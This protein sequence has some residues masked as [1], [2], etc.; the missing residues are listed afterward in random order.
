MGGW[1]QVW[2]HQI[3]LTS[4]KGWNCSWE[5][6]IQPVHRLEVFP[7]GLS[8]FPKM[9]C[10][11]GRG[12]RSESWVTP[13]LLGFLQKAPR[14]VPWC[15]SAP[16]AFPYSAHCLGEVE[17]PLYLPCLREAAGAHS[18]LRKGL[19]AAVCACRL[20][21]A[22]SPSRNEFMRVSWGWERAEPSL[23]EAVRQGRHPILFF[24]RCCLFVF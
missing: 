20:P 3:L 6:P 12:A 18:C 14:A 2:G 9:Y 24:C 23:S 5:E 22:Q 8:V 21:G 1:G 13:G 4:Q 17:H 7:G 16:R 10:W 19:G 11:W 15:I